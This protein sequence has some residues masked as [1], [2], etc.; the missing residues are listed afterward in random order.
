MQ[1]RTNGAKSSIQV[2][3]DG[4]SVF[5]K[6]ASF[7]ATSLSKVQFAQHARQM[8]DSYIDDVIVRR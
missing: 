6:N 1:V 3:F 5:S 8:G 7:G 4:A 2:W